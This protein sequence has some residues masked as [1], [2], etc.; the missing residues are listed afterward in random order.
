MMKYRM[1]MSWRNNFEMS[2]NYMVS[3]TKNLKVSLILNNR[4]G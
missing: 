3:H 1:N 4:F 2:V